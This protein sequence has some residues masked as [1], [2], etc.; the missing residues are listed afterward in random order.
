MALTSVERNKRYKEKHPERYKEQRLSWRKRNPDK[1]RKNQ[2]ASETR[3]KEKFLAIYGNICAC[4]G[5]FD[6]RFLTLDHVNGGGTKV[7]KQ[8]RSRL[9]CHRQALKL[10]DKQKY[11]T[12]CFNCNQAKHI[13]KEC[14]HKQAETII[15]QYIHSQK[16]KDG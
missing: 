13:Y 2:L 11:Q 1:V 6:K 9:F 8:N 7:R 12:L 3:V 4:C 14:P 15:D 10:V 5:E 16:N